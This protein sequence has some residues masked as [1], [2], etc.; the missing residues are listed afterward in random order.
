MSYL[1]PFPPKFKAMKLLVPPDLVKMNAQIEANDVVLELCI[2]GHM[3]I[4]LEKLSLFL[5]VQIV[6]CFNVYSSSSDFFDHYLGNI[7]DP[8]RLTQARSCKIWISR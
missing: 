4:S 2:L 8:R 3:A 6:F 1:R 5:L 7:V